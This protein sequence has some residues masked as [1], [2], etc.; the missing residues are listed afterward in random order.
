MSFSALRSRLMSHLRT[1][2][3][4]GELTERSLARL[5]GIS[6]PH[7]HNVLKGAKILSPE[8]EDQIL[9]TLRLSILDLYT[10]EELRAHL[11]KGVCSNRYRAVPV[12]DSLLGPGFPMPANSS[13]GEMHPVDCSLLGDVSQPRLARLG[14]DPEMA[15]LVQANRLVLLDYSETARIKLNPA[16]HYVASIGGSAVIRILI[17]E[18]SRLFA[19]TERTR[20]TPECWQALPRLEDPLRIVLAR[21]VWLDCR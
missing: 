8:L 18:G 19:A 4:N 3:Q 12:L 14:E 10:E 15:P 6:Q 16:M 21:V 9:F 7:I 20:A 11:G 5:S 1:R 17:N 2:I 13:H